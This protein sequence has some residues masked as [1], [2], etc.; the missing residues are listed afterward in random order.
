MKFSDRLDRQGKSDVDLR[1]LEPKPLEFSMQDRRQGVRLRNL[2]SREKAVLR[3]GL[4]EVEV[5]LKNESALGFG[6]AC[7]Q[8]LSAEI[9]DSLTLGTP[10]GWFDVRVA[11]SNA[12]PEGVVLGLQRGREIQAPKRG[13]AGVSKLALLAAATIG[14][15]AI[16]AVTIV[17]G[18]W[19]KP[20]PATTV[21]PPATVQP[22]VH[23]PP[24]R[25]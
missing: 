2:P 23:H 5:E 12:T 6:V 7:P 25:P 4:R 10:S 20:E 8:G 14:L 18:M 19:R 15:L 21:R 17:M 22:L 16:P 13:V 24:R 1:S 9:G 3:I 11:R